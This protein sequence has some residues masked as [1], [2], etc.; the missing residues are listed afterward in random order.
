[1]RRIVDRHGGQIWAEAT[2]G[3]GATFFFTLPSAAT[4][5]S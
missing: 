3:S 4:A 1:V 2:T 5:E